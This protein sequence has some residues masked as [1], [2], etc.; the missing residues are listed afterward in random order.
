MKTYTNFPI[1][2]TY[3]L[4]VKAKKFVEIENVNDIPAALKN[5]E[6]KSFFI[7][8][9]GSN[10]LF[11]NDFYDGTILKIVSKNVTIIE[12]EP[13]DDDNNIVY[14]NV[15]AGMDWNDFVNLTVEQNLYGA[16]NL[17]YIPGT[18]GASPI[19]NIGAYGQEVS[20]IISFV[21][22]YNFS[23]N[24]F[25]VLSN[26]DCNFGYRDSIFKNEL[27]NN[28]IITTVGFVLNKEK[29]L[30]INYKDIQQYIEQN[31]LDL[32]DL[33]SKDIANIVTN[34]RKKKLPHY[35]EL[36]NAGSFFK[37][38]IVNKGQ[39]EKLVSHFPE[40]AS[41]FYKISEDKYKIPAAFLIEKAGLK[42]YKDGNVGTH[43]NQPLVIVNYGA[44][45]GREIL[46]FANKIKNI[47]LEK[48]GIEL[49][50]EV[51]IIE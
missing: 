21:E 49:H 15:D 20:N 46:F 42:G 34:I 38:P 23:K 18:V 22:G 51:N 6:G 19:Q 37:N 5:I 17:A 32:N 40:A 10:T 33:T 50:S 4:T 3:G 9:S 29:N 24:D 25:D 44:E 13:D 45:T 27:K 1:P 48:F 28:F 11:L 31:N 2:N 12:N 47:V 35:D 36:P 16:E 43:I 26:S 8:G 7:L 39:Y 14:I 30:N 41:I